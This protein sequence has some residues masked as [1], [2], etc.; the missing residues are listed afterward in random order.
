MAMYGQWKG[1]F[2]EE[3]GAAKEKQKK[4]LPDDVAAHIARVRLLIPDLQAD[5]DEEEEEEM[6]ARWDDVD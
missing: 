4:N 2:Q 1:V 5:E 6:A 3:V